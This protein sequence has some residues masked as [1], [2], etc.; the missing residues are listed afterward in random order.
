MKKFKVFKFILLVKTL[1]IFTGCSD[2]STSLIP[3]SS[4]N[5]QSVEASA[6]KTKTLKYTW[7]KAEGATSYDLCEKE[8]TYAN[9]CLV[10]A[11]QTV[12]TDATQTIEYTL[13][14]L[15]VTDD[16][17]T[18]DYFIRASNA[19]GISLSSEISISESTLIAAIGYL[20]A[21]NVDANDVFGSA[22]ALSKDGTTLAV[23]A[24]LED[25]S[26]ESIQADNSAT[27]AGAVYVFHYQ[28]GTWGTPDYV[29]PFNIDAG[30]VFGF[31]LSLSSDGTVLAVGSLNE[32]SGDVSIPSDN[33]AG[34][35]GAVYVYRYTSGAW[36]TP[37]YLKASSITASDNFGRTVSLSGNGL[38]LAVGVPGEDSGTSSPSDNSQ[39]DAGA[40][41]VFRYS[42]SVW[43]SP[44][45]LKATDINA[46]DAFGVSVALSE[47]GNR[48][49]VGAPNDDSN[50]VPTDNSGVDVGAVYVFDY[51]GSAWSTPDFV[52]ASNM[53]NS[54]QFGF[55]LALS[56][57]GNTLAVGVPNE[58]SSS[59]TTP[60]ESA[61]AAGATYVYRYSGGS[62]GAPDYIKASNIDADDEFGTWVSLNSNGT[63]LAVGAKNEDSSGISDNNDSL[64]S[65]A[66]YIYRYESNTWGT[67]SL[68]KASNVDAGDLF[69][70]SLQ[71][72]NDG[73]SLFVGATFESSDSL[74]QN[75]DATASGAVYSY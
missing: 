25:S 75:N 67:A 24:P 17:I 53:S 66:V 60:D 74:N 29:K 54:D 41:Y 64:N 16:F 11:T 3:P 42:G 39:G 56:S 46:N 59:A 57:D 61:S 43:G 30:D 35:S 12:S 38:T 37:D 40:V 52:K 44:D 32:S 72:S 5:L 69:G 63:V 23:S 19:A 71:L 1:F 15:L 45:Y 9:N 70:S 7:S 51:L 47:D 65:G 33:T 8:S 13:P 6:D 14:T 55:N 4:F 62:W 21:S 26:S 34:A 10:L 48:L 49:A 2:S 18:K 28:N 36:S 58:D 20:K 68:I 73:N 22:I 31:S 50:S 27:D